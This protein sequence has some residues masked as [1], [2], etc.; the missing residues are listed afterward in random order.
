MVS[1]GIVF[2]IMFSSAPDVYEFPPSPS[3]SKNSSEPEF[4]G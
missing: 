4:G 3:L 2:F 1:S